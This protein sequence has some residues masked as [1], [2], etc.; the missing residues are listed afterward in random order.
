MRSLVVGNDC[1][2]HMVEST[3]FHSLLCGTVYVIQ[4]WWI[5]RSIIIECSLST[6]LEVDT[7]CS[8]GERFTVVFCTG[9]PLGTGTDTYWF[10]WVYMGL[11]DGGWM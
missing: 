6:V 9:P 11:Y 4:R 1:N 8:L 5:D 10:I 2:S 3:L 7:Q